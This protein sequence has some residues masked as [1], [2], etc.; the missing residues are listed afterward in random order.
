MSFASEP[1]AIWGDKS[2]LAPKND[3]A[4]IR[5]NTEYLGYVQEVSKARAT[6]E[7]L[8]YCVLSRNTVDMYFSLHF[9]LI[10]PLAKG[11]IRW[12]Q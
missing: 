3:E 6:V 12:I 9:S 1:T 7:R 8:Y 11:L 2:P 5:A 4:Y 10:P